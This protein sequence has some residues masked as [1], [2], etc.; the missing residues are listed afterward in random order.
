MADWSL[1]F[2]NFKTIHSISFVVLDTVIIIVNIFIVY[3]IYVHRRDETLFQRK[4]PTDELDSD[5]DFSLSQIQITTKHTHDE[6]Q[7]IY[8][9]ISPYYIMTLLSSITILL[10]FIGTLAL[11][12]IIPLSTGLCC[13]QAFGYLGLCGILDCLCYRLFSKNMHFNLNKLI[14]LEIFITTPCIVILLMCVPLLSATYTIN[15]C[16]HS[17][18]T[19]TTLITLVNCILCIKL[20][21]LFLPFFMLPCSCSEETP[22]W[23]RPFEHTEVGTRFYAISIMGTLIFLMCWL[24]LGVSI[25]YLGLISAI[26]GVIIYFILCE[27]LRPYFDMIGSLYLNALDLVTDI[28]VIF[29]WLTYSDDYLWATIQICVI[30]CAQIIQS[31]FIFESHRYYNDGIKFNCISMIITFVGFGKQYLGIHSWRNNQYL[32][33]YDT[34]RLIEI[35]YETM[36]TTAL[37]CYVMIRNQEFYTNIILSLFVGIVTI[38]YGLTKLLSKYIDLDSIYLLNKNK[39]Y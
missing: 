29:V 27:N 5:E 14:K 35:I 15:N 24:V 10:I 39:F 2:S 30:V 18:S 21:V 12:N 17:T 28:N 37:Q 13:A 19:T 31:V 25:Y 11:Q 23:L 36:P 16:F 7:I 4:V 32:I 6:S 33:R 34:L 38:S 26:F 20:V 22:K 9:N 8:D 1:E 3:G